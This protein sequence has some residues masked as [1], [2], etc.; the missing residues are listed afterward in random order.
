MAY[1]ILGIV[2]EVGKYI[3]LVTCAISILRGIIYW[4]I[5]ATPLWVS[6]VCI[7]GVVLWV[8]GGAGTWIIKFKRNRD[9]KKPPKARKSTAIHPE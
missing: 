3:T 9:A 1:K 2:R 4:K 7:L 6:Y 8:I 5:F